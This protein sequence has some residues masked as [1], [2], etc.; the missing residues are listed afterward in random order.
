MYGML[1]CFSQMVSRIPL[2]KI[3]KRVTIFPSDSTKPDVKLSTHSPGITKESNINVIVF[4][5]GVCLSDLWTEDSPPA[6]P[7]ALHSFVTAGQLATLLAAV[8]LSLSSTNLGAVGA[9]SSGIADVVVSDPSMN[10]LGM[11]G[12]LQVFV[13][14][15]WSQ[16]IE[17]SETTNGLRW[18]IPRQKLPLVIQFVSTIRLLE[19]I[20]R[21]V[22]SKVVA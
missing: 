5:P 3:F 18:L 13:F 8:V 4:E 21:C 16:P 11:V 10:L 9:I 2:K 7:V 20:R 6:I 1:P 19:L 14:T 12:H 15:D 22:L 17:Y